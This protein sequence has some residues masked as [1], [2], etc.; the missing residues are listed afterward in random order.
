MDSFCLQGI[1]TD[2]DR[3]AVYG[4]V[5]ARLKA[6]GT[7]LV[8]SAMFDPAR[9]RSDARVKDEATGGVYTCYGD[10]GLIDPQTGIVYV[11]LGEDQAAY[12]GARQIA[13]RA[14][15]LNRR[16]HRPAALRAEIEGAGFRVLSQ[17][18]GYG[19]NLV[20]VLS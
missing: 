10:D 17:G 16:H 18:G 6:D 7:Y 2:A 11:S 5:R 4:A 15:L 20:C 19:G 13:G 14:Y 8:S 12:G 3:R 1:V 9:L